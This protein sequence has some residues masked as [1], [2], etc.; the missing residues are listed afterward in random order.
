MKT[1]TKKMF[2]IGAMVLYST[3]ANAQLFKGIMDGLKNAKE[4]IVSSA[5]KRGTDDPKASVE[6]P[7]KAVSK[8]VMAYSS[9]STKE[10]ED[11][12]K[13]GTTS[14]KEISFPTS[15]I[16]G[17]KAMCSFPATTVADLRESFKDASALML[18]VY[19]LRRA[20]VGAS[21]NPK[22]VDFGLNV[23][24]SATENLHKSM[25][26]T[27]RI[28]LLP[29]SETKRFDS[30]LQLHLSQTLVQHFNA[31]SKSMGADGG[32]LPML[33]SMNEGKDASDVNRQIAGPFNE[34]FYA[35][36]LK[37][38]EGASY[39][40]STV[41]SK[42]VTAY[43]STLIHNLAGSA[44]KFPAP[45]GDD[46]TEIRMVQAIW[47][48]YLASYGYL[49]GDATQKE[50]ESAA[51]SS[52]SRLLKITSQSWIQQ[53]KVLAP[54]L[55]AAGQVLDTH[56]LARANYVGLLSI[57][58]IE[59]FS[60]MSALGF[61][62]SK[63]QCVA[64]DTNTL[65]NITKTGEA[66]LKVWN[67]VDKESNPIF[68]ALIRG[69]QGTQPGASPSQGCVGWGCPRATDL[70]RQKRF[71]DLNAALNLMPAEKQIV[72]P[73]KN[74]DLLVEALAK[75]M[76]VNDISGAIGSSKLK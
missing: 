37:N 68:G 46:L 47:N 74:N 5:A 30:Y 48:S 56:A 43:F 64:F 61:N 4:T 34:N 6:N 27:V 12:I 42:V 73:N 58:P 72:D 23:D 59:V 57:T 67:D 50:A 21:T 20:K 71:D 25:S 35:N 51:I 44:D 7:N 17:S 66:A 15:N 39:L 75:T 60:K 2:S 19:K 62:S 8:V 49:V 11:G 55:A 24:W 33:A 54:E 65:E 52:G 22:L 45:R 41:D 63:L 69:D 28:R 40:M 14:S 32:L 76:N 1:N 31:I 13:N 18:P 9:S 29:L 16:A 3:T 70:V 53:W 36:V 38:F 10:L 26:K